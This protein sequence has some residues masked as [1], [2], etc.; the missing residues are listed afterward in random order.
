MKAQCKDCRF[1]SES[2]RWDNAEISWGEC[3]RHAPKAAN[4]GDDVDWI[5][6]QDDDWCGEFLV[7]GV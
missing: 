3:R 1:W 6:T 5:E 4:R 2:E 7:W